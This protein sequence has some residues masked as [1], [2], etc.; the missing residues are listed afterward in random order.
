MQISKS[1]PKK[2]SVLC[3]FKFFIY[4]RPH[5]SSSGADIVEL[6]KF[7]YVEFQKVAHKLALQAIKPQYLIL[8]SSFGH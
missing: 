1:K 6:I 2:I 5:L 8:I 4:G 3:T 7:V